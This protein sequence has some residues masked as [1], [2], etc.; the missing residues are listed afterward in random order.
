MS[1]I[2]SLECCWKI[3]SLSNVINSFCFFINK[4]YLSNI[5][6]SKNHEFVIYLYEFQRLNHKL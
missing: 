3:N 2:V 6:I 1:P 5:I 4:G